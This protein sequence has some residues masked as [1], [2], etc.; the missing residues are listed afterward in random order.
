MSLLIQANKCSLLCTLLSAIYTY[1]D[2]TNSIDGRVKITLP[3]VIMLMGNGPYP[4]FYHY[5][6]LALF[7]HKATLA[8]R[9][10]GSL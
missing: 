6:N 5:N 9:V 2:T 3:S 8:K 7:V 4:L 1:D 10:G